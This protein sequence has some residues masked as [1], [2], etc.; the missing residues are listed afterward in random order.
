[1]AS[2]RSTMTSHPL[3]SGRFPISVHFDVLRRFMAISRNGTEPVS[4]SAAE[5]GS[6]PEGAATLNAGFLSDA[7][8]LVEEAA[9]KF[10]P[11]GLAMQFINTQAMDDERGRKLL[12]SVVGKLWFGRTVQA[13]RAT[14]PQVSRGQLASALAKEA[15]DQGPDTGPATIV[16]LE[17]LTY[18]GLVPPAA[19]GAGGTAEATRPV[20][21]AESASRAPKRTR[22]EAALRGEVSDWKALRT[23]DFELRIRATPVAVRRLRKHLDLLEEELAESP[24]ASRPG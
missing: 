10:K 3:P 16:L 5:G 23:D 7:G 11:T 4:P 20:P 21:G 24:R 13:L 17:Y 14:D 12:R 19:E 2:G 8:F 1:V 9:G 15:P 22:G 18:A 6:V